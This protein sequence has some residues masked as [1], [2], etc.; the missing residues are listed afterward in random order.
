MHV[1][2]Y[3]IGPMDN[4]TYVIVDEATGEAAVVDPSFGSD[5]V[6]QDIDE[7]GW[8]PIVLLN[9]HAHIDHIVE[10]ALFAERYGTPLAL[11][12]DDVPLLEATAEQA[13][14]FGIPEPKRV[15][16]GR[17]LADGDEV[18]IGTGV[19]RVIHTPGHSPGGVCFLGE[20]WVIV[21]DVLFQGSIGR[22]D[23]PGGD[24][25]LLLESIRT[26]LLTLPPSTIVYPGHGPTTAVGREARSNP[27]LT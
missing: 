4:N 20:G 7:Q 22:A 8:R 6:A 9:T 14:W 27:F 18:Q 17:L 11:H 21:G 19:V 12:A 23:L 15:S 1:A 2:R 26:R 3:A 10:N 25:S 5:R 13:E 24:L 16:P